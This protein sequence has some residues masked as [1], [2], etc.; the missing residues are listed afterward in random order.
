MFE[1]LGVE[2]VLSELISLLFVQPVIILPQFMK[3]AQLVVVRAFGEVLES[4]RIQIVI[5]DDW[6]NVNADRA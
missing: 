1:L 5:A 6:E 2:A 4:R 3:V